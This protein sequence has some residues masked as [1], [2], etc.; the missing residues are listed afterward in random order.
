[1]WLF[2]FFLS[3]VQAILDLYC[4]HFHIILENFSPFFSGLHLIASLD[5][6]W[7]LEL[8]WIQTLDSFNKIPLVALIDAIS[9][10]M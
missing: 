3:F 6:W 5:S 7:I 2:S 10:S 8:D 1:M 9:L 4:E